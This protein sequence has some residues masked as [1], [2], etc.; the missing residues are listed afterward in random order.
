MKTL[1]RVILLSTLVVTSVGMASANRQG[2]H[3][4][5]MHALSDLEEARAHLEKP[6]SNQKR[7]AEEANAMN[8]IDDAIDKINRAAAEDGKDIKNH[9]PVDARLERGHDRLLK[10]EELLEVA[11]RDVS[12]RE[13]NPRNRN[14]QGQI[15]DDIKEAHHIIGRLREPHR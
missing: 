1:I 11:L 4:T 15:I 6:A 5:Y 9:Q 14:L 2:Q 7:Q 12:T 3:P 8:K 10:V 13:D